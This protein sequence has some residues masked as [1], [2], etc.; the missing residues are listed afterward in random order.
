MLKTVRN[1]GA[2]VLLAVAPYLLAVNLVLAC[3]FSII[4]FAG[5]T[6]QAYENRTY[7]LIAL[8]VMAACG[9]TITL[10]GVVL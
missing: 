10:L 3:I 8:N 7:N 6:W 9:Y 1:W 4:G 5:L 2:A